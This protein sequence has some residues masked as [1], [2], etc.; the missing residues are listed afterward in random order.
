MGRTLPTYRQVLENLI[1]EWNLFKKA[2]RKEEKKIFEDLMAKAR[3]HASAAG[4]NPR[5][6]PMESFFMSILLEMEKE[7]NELKKR[8]ELYER[9]DN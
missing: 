9:M 4:Y 6:N 1:A 3:R 8:L 5:M 7:L 2:L